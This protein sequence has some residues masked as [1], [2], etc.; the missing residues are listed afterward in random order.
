MESLNLQRLEEEKKEYL[1]QSK[2]RE[3]LESFPQMAA[4]QGQKINFVGQGI[5]NK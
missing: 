3:K 4:K 1:K 5:L 2:Q